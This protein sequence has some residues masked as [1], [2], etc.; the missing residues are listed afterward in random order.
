MET[1]GFVCTTTAP[2]STQLC[3]EVGSRLCNGTKPGV[4]GLVEGDICSPLPGP[5]PA[6]RAWLRGCPE[7]LTDPAQRTS[8]L[9]PYPPRQT[10]VKA[11][12]SWLGPAR[13]PSSSQ[14]V[15]I[16]AT[17]AFPPASVTSMGID[18]TKGGRLL[19][20]ASVCLQFQAIQ[21][22][23]TSHRIW[24]WAGVAG[25][26]HREVNL[27][28]LVDPGGRRPSAQLRW[29]G[30][31]ELGGPGSVSSAL[32]RPLCLP[33]TSI[34]FTDRWAHTEVTPT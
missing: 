16:P 32:V 26:G 12:T 24:D 14:L 20:N 15:P 3:T 21:R 18:M 10:G 9:T 5:G 22:D 13:S 34:D 19:T 25:V 4:Q 23:I 8:P 17:R 27:Q 31:G 1:L 29:G 2:H 11:D 6:S 33:V 7:L 30:G 28:G